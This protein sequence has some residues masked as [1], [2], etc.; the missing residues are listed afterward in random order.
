[1]T[2]GAAA[3]DLTVRGALDRAAANV[4]DRFAN[5]PLVEAGVREA[6]ARA[7]NGLSVFDPAFTQLERALSLRRRAQGA[8]D[9]DVLK[10]EEALASAYAGQRRFPPAQALLERIAVGVSG[11]AVEIAARIGAVQLVLERRRGV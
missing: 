11:A 5:E 7:Y 9:P 4:G 8:D 3:P 2:R 6:I 10:A 1:M